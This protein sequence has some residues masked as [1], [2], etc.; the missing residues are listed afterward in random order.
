M[1]WS[2][3]L[4]IWGLLK[5]CHI[6]KYT[7][8]LNPFEPSVVVYLYNLSSFPPLLKSCT[9]TSDWAWAQ[10]VS[11]PSCSHLGFPT[12]QNMESSPSQ[13]TDSGFITKRE[14]KAND[15]HLYLSQA[16]AGTRA[17]STFPGSADVRQELT[18]ST[19]E[20][21]WDSPSSSTP[22]IPGDGH[23]CNQGL[24][25]ETLDVSLWAKIAPAASALHR[26]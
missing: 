11:A 12:A 3:K 20:C 8:I 9:V 7:V 18:G 6:K 13:P 19:A 1:R 23:T 5:E 2:W 22:G 21:P 4:S 24:T 16:K 25:W 10:W 26:V 17:V 14:A 15:F